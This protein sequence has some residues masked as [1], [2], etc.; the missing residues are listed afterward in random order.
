MPTIGSGSDDGYR[1]CERIM[2]AVTGASGNIGTEL[3]RLLS[4]RGESVLAISR[5]PPAHSAPDGIQWMQADLADKAALPG[6]LSGAERLFLLTG[7]VP[8]MVRLQKNAIAAARE[9]G[10]P[11]VV[12]LSA[13]G[14][15]DHSKSV[16]GVWHYN[17]ERTLRES[18]LDWTILRPHVF[19]QNLLDQRDSI[20][21]RSSFRSPSG[22]AAI[23]MIDTRDIA[24]AAAVTLTESGHAGKRYTLTGSEP[25]SWGEAVRILSDVI[26]RELTYI[27]ETEEQAWSR[28]YQA[29]APPWLIA[30]QLELARYQRQG[31]GTD[32]IT[33][34]VETLT[35]RPP[36]TFREFASDFASHLRGA[37]G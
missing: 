6:I 35:G 17:V 19:M 1:E 25:I 7:N 34:S 32:L 18:G 23:P 28:L 30:A 11:H 8:D 20:R 12:K 4:E 2:I 9:A 5:N 10:V 16:I 29:G 15:S 21:D 22:D 24:G 33:D 31:G 27:A 3:L 37:S 36:R 26:G 14:A 13:L